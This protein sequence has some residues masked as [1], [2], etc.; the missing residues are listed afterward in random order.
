[1][2]RSLP[3]IVV[4]SILTMMSVGFWNFG[5]GTSIHDFSSGP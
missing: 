1:M 4:V 5:S 2:C 3:Q